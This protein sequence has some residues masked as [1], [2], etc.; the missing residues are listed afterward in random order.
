MTGI[1]DK[2]G[3]VG[4][5]PWRI[6]AE[7]MTLSGYEPYAVSPFECASNY[8]AIVT[9][10]N[11]TV[12]TASTQ[13]DFPSGTYDVGVNYFDLIGGVSTWQLYLNDKQLAQWIG[14]MEDTLGHAPSVYLDGTSNRRMT[15]HG[16][17]IAKNDTLKIVGTPNGIEP[18][19][20]DYVVFLPP[21]VVD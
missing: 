17:K 9:T 13:L 11:T 7:S 1:P 15:F 10:A 6:E 5:H 8:T 2:A 19:P 3:R 16:V 4:H 12:G 21:G 14:N 18:A 20:L